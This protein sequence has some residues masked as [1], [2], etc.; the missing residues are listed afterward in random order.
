MTIRPFQA[1]DYDGVRKVFVETAALGNPLANLLIDRR[2]A[3]DFMVRQYVENPRNVAWVAEADGRVVG[4]LFGAPDVR[5]HERKALGLLLP[6]EIARAV[7]SRRFWKPATWLL[8]VCLF[9]TWRRGGFDAGKYHADYPAH[10]HVNLLREVRRRGLGRRLVEQFESH[11]RS[12]GVRGVY[13]TVAE[14]NPRGCGF[15]EK[16]GYRRKGKLP[17]Y[18][19]TGKNFVVGY[20]LVYA[21]TL[22]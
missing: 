10:L 7:F 2:L 12:G 1:G 11:L 9:K 5:R 16:M 15:F 13:A 14:N 18:W 3:A 4:Y 21:K 6:R 17:Y 8:A 22:S 20:R 19:P